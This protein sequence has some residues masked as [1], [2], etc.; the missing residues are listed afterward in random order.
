MQSRRLGRT[1]FD[2][3][4]VG[5][6]AW[7]IGGPGW[8]LS[9]GPQ[10]D[11]ASIAT[12]HRALELG[13]NW[14]DTAALYG[15]GHS[16]EVIAHA[17][18]GLSEKPIV[19]TKCGRI[20][21]EQGALL[22]VLK[23]RAL[24]DE[25][26]RSRERLRSETIDLYFLHFPNEDLEEGWSTIAELKERGLVRA[27]GVSNFSVAQMRRAQAIAHID[28]CQPSYS[29]IDRE[30]EAHLLPFCRFHEIGVVVYSPQGGGLLTG[31]MTRERL[32][33][34]PHDD[35]RVSFGDPRWKEPQLSRSLG[36][37]ELLAGI[38]ARRGRT[39]GEVAIA[40]TLRHPVVTSAIVGLRQPDQVDGIIGAPRLQLAD[41][42]LA[43]I[44]AFLEA[45]S[46]LDDRQMHETSKED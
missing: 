46:P 1:D 27:I 3:S 21:D 30:A 5:L 36:L 31:A 9:W 37:V 29:L 15:R 19:A 11:R 42:E 12:I 16:E 39:V 28:V 38:G 6:G 10:D 44:D 8:K 32:A 14:I 26:E 24:L 18:A 2:L 33:R 35:W 34:L 40:W 23:R 13:I 22:T 7:A 43:E 25:F 20:E 45:W 41:D 17:L 4:P